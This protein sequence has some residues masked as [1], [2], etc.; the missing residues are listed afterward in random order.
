MSTSTD[1]GLRTVTLPGGETIPVLGAGTW[2][3]AERPERRRDE[4][5]ALQLAVDIGMTVIDTAEMEAR[6]RNSSPRRWAIAGPRSSWSA[7]FCLN[8]RR[9]AARFR[10]ARRA[11]AG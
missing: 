8:M 1:Q 9:D 2:N 11:F 4:I 10:R 7:R 6:P 5:A 3:M